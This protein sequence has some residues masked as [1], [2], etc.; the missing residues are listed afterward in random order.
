MAKTITYRGIRIVTLEND[1]SLP[2]DCHE[3]DIVI[4]QDKSGWWT[5]FMDADGELTKYDE[6]FP[7]F[8]K[9]MQVARAAAEY[10]AD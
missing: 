4:L 3:N 2:N 9:A 8:E 5:C 10:S 7:S 1:E 6:A